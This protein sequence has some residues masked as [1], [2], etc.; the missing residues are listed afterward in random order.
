MYVQGS[1]VVGVKVDEGVVVAA[2]KRFTMGNLVISGKAKK[3]HV[4]KK[5]V[6]LGAAW[7]YADSQSIVTILKHELDYYELS[8]KTSL[9]V[10]GTVKL[11]SKILYSSKMLPYLT[12]IIVG[13]VDSSGPHLFVLDSLGGFSEEKIAALGTGA[14]LSLGVL[15]DNYREDMSIR[16]AEKLAVEAVRTALKRDSLSG[17]GI[18]V[19]VVERNGESREYTIQ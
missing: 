2:D 15:E 6:V 18:D 17:D 7:M 5:N 8:S 16:E 13:G 10:E 4:I 12:E 1:T 9:S 3:V 11:L 19:A 14:T